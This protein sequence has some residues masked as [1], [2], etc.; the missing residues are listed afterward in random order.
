MT[1]ETVATL[2]PEV[3][4]AHEVRRGTK[5]PIIV[6]DV[7]PTVATVGEFRP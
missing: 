5:L 7:H 1:L 2:E 3:G 4:E 6:R